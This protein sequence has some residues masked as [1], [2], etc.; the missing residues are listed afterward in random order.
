MD[1]LAD[2]LKAAEAERN[3]AVEARRKLEDKFTRTDKGLA[4]LKC[5]RQQQE[6][7]KAHT[8]LRQ[9]QSAASENV[10]SRKCRTCLQLCICVLVM[11]AWAASKSQRLLADVQDG[12]WRAGEGPAAS[13][14]PAAA[15]KGGVGEGRTARPKRV[16]HQR[17]AAAQHSRK[18][19]GVRG[20]ETV[21][22]GSW[23]QTPRLVS[24]AVNDK[25]EQVGFAF[26]SFLL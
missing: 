17:R 1:S 23:Q 10:S 12:L 7:E 26:F 8:A 13:L 5:T 11:M 25:I 15:G 9:L 3:G 16:W 24:N 20:A 14:Q 4:M 2:S 6:L 19:R 18:S 22:F 21:S